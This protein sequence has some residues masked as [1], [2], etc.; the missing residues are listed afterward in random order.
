MKNNHL[1]SFF[2]ERMSHNVLIFVKKQKVKQ[3][4]IIIEGIVFWVDFVIEFFLILI[5]DM[6][7]KN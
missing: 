2:Y 4:N 5:R 3:K 7:V 1:G 6:L